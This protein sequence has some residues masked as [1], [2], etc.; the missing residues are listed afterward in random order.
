M[1]LTAALLNSGR[2]LEVFSAGIQVAGQNVANA[3]TPGYIR[4]TLVLEAADPFQKGGLIFGTGVLAEGIVQEI[5]KFLE[6]RVHTANSD[7]SASLARE[8]ILNNSKHRFAN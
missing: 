1:G 2:A 7:A 8:T 5:D 4:E 3:N 6:T